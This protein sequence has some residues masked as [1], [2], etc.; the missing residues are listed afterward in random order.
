MAAP[1]KLKEYI[2]KI[3]KSFLNS[4]FVKFFAHVPPISWVVYGIFLFLGKRLVKKNEAIQRAEHLDYTVT[5]NGTRADLQA[6]LDRIVYDLVYALGYVGAIVATYEQGDVLPVRAVYVD[7]KL[8]SSEQ[9]QFW[10]QQISQFTREQPIRLADPTVARVY[11]H[12]PEYQNNLSVKA[13]D[14]GEPVISTELFDLFTPVIPNSTRSAIRGIQDALKITQVIAVPFFLNTTSNGKTEQEYVGNLFAA[15]RSKITEADKLILTT[16]TRHIAAAILSERRHLHVEI[17]QKLILDMHSNLASEEKILA[18]IAQG[19]V[20]ELGY[21]GAMVA[22]YEADD[23]LPVRAIYVDPNLVSGEQIDKWEDQVS[24]LSLLGMPISLRNPLIARVYVR[25]NKY[26]DNLGVRAAKAKEPVTST[27]LFELFTPV[28]PEVAYY[29]VEGIQDSLGIKQV[30]S[31]PFFLDQQFVGNLFAATQSQK[32][33]SWEI[34]VLRTFGHQAAA[35][36]RNAALFRQSEDR[37]AAA[38]ILGRMA[39]SASASVHAFRGHIGVV[40]GNLQILK[41]LDASDRDPEQRRALM[42]KLIP[43]VITRLN[44][45]ADL[46]EKLQ[47]PWTLTIR[48]PVDI[49]GC[50]RHAL[51]KVIPIPENWLHL[52]FVDNLSSVYASQEIL[53]EI[54][55]NVIK[56]S[57]EA[58]AEKG[59]QRHLWIESCMRDSSTIEINIRDNGIGVKPENIGKVFEI[60]WTTKPGALGMGLFWARDYIEGLGGSVKL[61]SIWKEGT[62][63]SI[64]IPVHSEGKSLPIK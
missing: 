48:E 45:I 3:T 50:L 5:G 46:L 19:I 39:F 6:T 55:R 28:I 17:M 35:G 10:E 25:D 33:S 60:K 51:G 62:T 32:F 16:L 27:K 41:N 1:T 11:L 8:A 9:I 58:L 21:A 30:I 7:P 37:R 12:R 49:N 54:F 40:R 43:P 64:R 56:N 59:G 47:S 29:A 38:E 23:A 4:V 26:K 15:S 52:S 36:L 63:C 44:D 14:A 57:V 31:V 24:Q 53:V 2:K 18:A 20:T 22:T 13:S 34:E 42:E 61:E